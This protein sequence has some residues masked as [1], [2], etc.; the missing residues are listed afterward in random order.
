VPWCEGCSR[1]WVQTTLGPD[2]ACPDC[3]RVIVEGGVAE[4]RAPWHFKLLMVAVV[5]Y[6]GFRAV[7]AAA[8]VAE[9]L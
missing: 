9:R 5:A 8:W 7:E 4:P 3:G 6:L 2:G 1:Y